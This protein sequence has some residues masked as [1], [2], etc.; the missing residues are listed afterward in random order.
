[1]I[2]SHKKLHNSFFIYDYIVH[3][4]VAKIMPF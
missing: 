3:R 2:S 4:G 1:L